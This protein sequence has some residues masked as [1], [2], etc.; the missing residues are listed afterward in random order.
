MAKITMKGLDEYAK[1]LGRLVVKADGIIKYAVYPAAGEALEALKANTPVETG[2]LRDSEAL[3]HFE[4]KNGFIY[5]TIIF[6]GYDQN[7]VPNSVKARVH[8]SGSSKQQKKPFIRPTMN[9][10]KNQLVET[11]RTTLDEA[12]QKAM[13]Q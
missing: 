2:D 1:D 3:S 5:T 4:D 7:G 6:P 11:M 10:I 13:N 8:E 9:A 12:I